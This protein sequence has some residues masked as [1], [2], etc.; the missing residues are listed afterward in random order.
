[1]MERRE[2]RKHNGRRFLG[3]SDLSG[4]SDE[5]GIGGVSRNG[6]FVEFC[7]PPEGETAFLRRS[8]PAHFLFGV[9]LL[10]LTIFLLNYC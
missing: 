7:R 1:M 2:E 9:A 3:R 4:D 8:N 5:Y 10:F 6:R